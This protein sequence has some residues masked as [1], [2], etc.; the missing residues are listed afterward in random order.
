NNLG[1]AYDMTTG[2]PVDGAFIL[3]IDQNSNGRA[4]EDELLETK[5]EA[6][7]MVATGK[8]P[9]PPSRA[10]NLVTNGKPGGIVRDFIGW[11]L[12]DGQEF[13]GEAGYIQLTNEQ[14]GASLEKLQ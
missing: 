14:L 5:A 1:Y 10:L 6:I 13:V 12:T 7:E 11:V 3:P 9:S 8:Y 2:E 4:D